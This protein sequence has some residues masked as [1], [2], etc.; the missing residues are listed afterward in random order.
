METR[1]KNRKR[2][3]GPDISAFFTPMG[4]LK[5]AAVIL[6]LVFLATRFGGKKESSAAF[7][8]VAEAVKAAADLTPMQEGDNQMIKRLYG[9]DPGSFEGVMLYYPTTNMGAE[10]ILLVRLADPSQAAAVEEAVAQRV[11]TQKNSFEGY[12]VQ[13]FEMLENSVTEVWPNY[14]LFVSAADPGA[15]REAFL[16]AL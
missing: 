5:W 7:P 6:M 4:L 1:A 14:V 8:A 9:L 11:T 10:E 13:Q 3:N 16:S 2:N 12:G 15:V